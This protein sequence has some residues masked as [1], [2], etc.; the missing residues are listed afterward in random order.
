MKQFLLLFLVGCG[1]ASF[2]VPPGETD[3]GQDAD[4]D[5]SQDVVQD[6]SECD[7]NYESEASN[8]CDGPNPCWQWET[9]SGIL[10]SKGQSCPFNCVCT[11]PNEKF[12]KPIP[13]GCGGFCR[14]GGCLGSK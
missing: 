3:A 10:I 5:A 6:V 4:A 11:T 12:G 9:T 7:V 13:C 14:F 2:Y 1:G 8:P